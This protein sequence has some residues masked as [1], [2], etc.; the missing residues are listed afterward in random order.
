MKVGSEAY[1]GDMIDYGQMTV[2]DDAEVELW[3]IICRKGSHSC[4]CHLT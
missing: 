4:I 1:G 2:Y 3:D